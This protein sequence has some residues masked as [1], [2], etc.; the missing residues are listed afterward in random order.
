MSGMTSPPA[1]T[2]PFSQFVPTSNG[3][4]SQVDDE[5][6]EGVWGYLIPLDN[7]FGDTLVLR[8][9]NACP[10]AVLNKSKKGKNGKKN[11]KI[12][13]YEK[14]EAAYEETKIKG[15]ASGGYLIGRH[16]ECGKV[17]DLDRR[18][19]ILMMDHN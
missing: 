12:D 8:E 1:E 13:T 17:A 10:V 3:L 7:K 5:E 11:N 19:T 15:I 6:K 4:S 18:W 9:R 14:Q 2:Q 16:P